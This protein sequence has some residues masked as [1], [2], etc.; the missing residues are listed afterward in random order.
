MDALLRGSRTVARPNSCELNPTRSAGSLG[1]PRGRGRRRRLS[2]FPGSIDPSTMGSASSGT[3][4][5]RRGWAASPPP[6]SSSSTHSER[7]RVRSSLTP[8]SQSV[9][10]GAPA[11]LNAIVTDGAGVPA[12]GVTVDSV[13]R[14]LA[15]GGVTTD[16]RGHASFF[17]TPSR[18]GTDTVMAFEDIDGNGV[19]RAEPS[20]TGRRRSGHRLVLDPADRIWS[21]DKTPPSLPDHRPPTV[22]LKKSAQ[23]T[24]SR[25]PSQ[26]AASLRFELLGARAS[27]AQRPLPAAGPSVSAVRQGGPAR[28]PEAEGE[29][30]VGSRRSS[31]S[32]ARDRHRPSRATRRSRPSDRQ[33]IP[34]C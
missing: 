29:E 13:S 10:A 23:G 1:L 30:A 20:R 3:S 26:R 18:A 28:W 24:E 4:T 25:R 9:Y 34:A 11:A 12:T 33:I 19:L 27:R 32:G 2:R 15:G 7:R 6:I 31:A 17:Y 14:P 22:K 16:G 5:T 8:S 21:S